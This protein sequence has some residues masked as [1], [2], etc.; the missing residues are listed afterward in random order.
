MRKPPFPYVIVAGGAVEVVSRDGPSR[1]ALA[2]L[3]EVAVRTTEEG[4]FSDDVFWV[5][6]SP[7]ETLIVPWSAEG[8]DS[9]MPV[10]QKLEGFDNEAVIEA[11]ASIDRAIFPVWKRAVR[12]H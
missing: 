10:L 11:S 2:D 5:L 6:R 4:P 8:A 7:V 3:V 1:L 9:L 12:V